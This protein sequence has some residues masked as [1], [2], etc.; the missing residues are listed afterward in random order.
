[1]E[2]CVL[3]HDEVQH[4]RQRLSSNSEAHE[5]RVAAN[6]FIILEGGI[7]FDQSVS[8][9]AIVNSDCEGQICCPP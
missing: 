1:M 3:H 8:R 6:V 7:V 2:T 9:K 4:H 5:D